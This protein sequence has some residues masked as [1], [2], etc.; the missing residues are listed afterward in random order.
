[1]NDRETKRL[2][3]GEIYIVFFF[4][5]SLRCFKTRPNLELDLFYSKIQ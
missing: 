2:E 5:S 3:T 1:M 4:F